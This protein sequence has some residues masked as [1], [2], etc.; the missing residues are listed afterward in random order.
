MSKP[1]ALLIAN[2]QATRVTAPTRDLIARAFA[3][4]TDLEVA[5][6]EDRDHATKLAADAA[7]NGVKIV[8]ALGGDGTVNECAQGLLRTDT[9]LAVVPSGGADVFARTL[10]IPRDTVEA[11]DILIERIESRVAAEPRG[12]GTLL[13]PSDPERVFLFNAG[14]GFDASI[15]ASV[16]RHPTRKRRYGQAYFVAQTL[17]SFFFTYP[18]RGVDVFVRSDAG[19]ATGRFVVW[20]VSDPYTYL[21]KRG[22][23]LCTDADPS[24]GL[25]ALLMQEMPTLRTLRTALRGFGRGVRS[26]KGITILNGVTRATVETSQ[27]LLSHTDGEIREELTHARVELVPGGLKVL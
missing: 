16:D 7:T 5:W 24:K 8:I 14:I 19:D 6:T 25:S 10:G 4:V 23:H 13:G 27:P 9:A 2:P 3:S 22:L 11:A 20:C 18:R 1:S 26:A 12:V 17:K 15:V 21:G